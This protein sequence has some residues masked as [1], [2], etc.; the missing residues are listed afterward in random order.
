MGG[1]DW[2]TFVVAL[3]EGR[4]SLL[5]LGGKVGMFPQEYDAFLGW[6]AV[7]FLVAFG[8][9]APFFV[10]GRARHV[11][12]LFPL[13]MFIFA[14]SGDAFMLIRDTGFPLVG[15]IRTPT[16]M[17]LMPIVI[18]SMQA[19]WSLAQ[20]LERTTPALRPWIAAFS[21]LVL[22]LTGAQLYS[23]LRAVS[24]STPGVPEVTEPHLPTNASGSGWGTMPI[25]QVTVDPV[26]TKRSLTLNG[27]YVQAIEIGSLISAAGLLLAA[28]WSLRMRT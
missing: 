22:S 14:L 28:G 23:N 10:P 17:I 21:I 8:L 26:D 7:L 13:A 4:A 12:L 19:A 15:G 5:E 25:A 11:R 27:I 20:V 18:L 6:P 2:P 16:R 24:P 3:T 1:Y 9:V